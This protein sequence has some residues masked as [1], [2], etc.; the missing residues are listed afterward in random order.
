MIR[1]LVGFFHRWQSA[2]V[3]GCRRLEDNRGSATLEL[4][5]VF[6]FLAAPIM[7]GTAETAFMIYDSI[8]VSNAAHAG[9]M[10]GMISA[11]FAQNTATIQA[12][13]QA[14]AP[15]LKGNM[16]VT[17]TTYF[18]C[19]ATPGGTQYSTQTAATQACGSGSSNHSLQ[20]IQVATSA[21]IN[22]PVHIP[23]LPKTWTLTG[24]SVMEVQE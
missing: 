12:A 14:E 22:P 9:A 18:A 7:L 16:T 11:T 19:S 21:S 17:P 4:A 23:G 2:V 10:Y 6:S 13:A 24:F 3:A 8:E 5:L 15:D 20:F 1:S